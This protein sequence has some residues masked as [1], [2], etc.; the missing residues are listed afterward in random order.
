MEKNAILEI[1]K[2]HEITLEMDFDES[3]QKCV[4]TGRISVINVKTKITKT[5]ST[6]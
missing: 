6:K 3:T 4:P 5:Q 1:I 2:K